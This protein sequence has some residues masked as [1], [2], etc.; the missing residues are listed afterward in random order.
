MGSFD[1]WAGACRAR[2]RAT[3]RRAGFLRSAV[4]N[5]DMNRGSEGEEEDEAGGGEDDGC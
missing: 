5:E 2:G 1:G 4:V 3:I